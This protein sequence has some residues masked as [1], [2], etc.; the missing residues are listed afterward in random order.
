MAT[1]E[2]KSKTMSSKAK[3]SDKTKKD[4]YMK[5]V[6]RSENDMGP[7]AK[8]KKAMMERAKAKQQAKKETKAKAKC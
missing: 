4:N 6:G 2:N 7:T 1:P 5:T 3:V 8:T